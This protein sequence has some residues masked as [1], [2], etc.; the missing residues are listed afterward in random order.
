MDRNYTE[1][2]QETA[3]LYKGQILL[4]LLLLLLLLFIQFAQIFHN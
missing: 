2:K 1:R 3:D 4:L